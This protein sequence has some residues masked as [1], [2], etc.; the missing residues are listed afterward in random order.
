MVVKKGTD[1]KKKIEDTVTRTLAFYGV[2]SVIAG[3]SG[4][5]DSTALLLALTHSNAEIYAVHCNFHLRGEESMRDQRV[6]E[7]FC[8]NHGIQLKVVDFDVDAFRLDNPMSVEMA[9]RDLRYEEFRSLKTEVNADRIAI[10]HNA[11]D[12][13]ETLLLNLFRGSGVT[14]LRAMVPDNGE[15]IRPL[16]EIPRIEIEEYVTAK[17]ERYIVDSSNLSSDYRRNFLRNEI[18]PM[19]ETRWKGVRKAISSSIVNLRSEANVLKWA[20]REWLREAN[21]LPLQTISDSPDK[22]WIIYRF[23]SAHGATRDIALEILDVFYKKGGK[24][25][26]VGKSW[27]SGKG[28]LIFVMKGLKYEE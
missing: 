8:K 24:Q 15:I 6:V 2:K 12:N 1:I 10:A 28:R 3:V 21:F 4:G 22:F 14:G 25:T 5:A 19:L 9:C 7:D 23:A 26:I 18:I 16:L 11:D 17:K 20:G 27:K 13:I